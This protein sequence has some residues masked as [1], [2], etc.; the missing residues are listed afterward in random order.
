[1]FAPMS[2]SAYGI[3]LTANSVSQIKVFNEMSWNMINNWLL[4][5]K[6]T[7]N[8]N[9]LTHIWDVP[10]PPRM[11]NIHEQIP[12]VK[13]PSPIV[14]LVNDHCSSKKAHSSYHWYKWKAPQLIGGPFVNCISLTLN[15]LSPHSEMH[16]TNGIP[17]AWVPFHWTPFEHIGQPSSFHL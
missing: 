6:L 5:F 9:F 17:M 14:P 3:S 16:F 11:S 1:M 15:I 13:T 4:W 2:Y 12:I 8:G 7:T 10:F